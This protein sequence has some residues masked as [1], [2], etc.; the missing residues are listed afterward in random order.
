MFLSAQALNERYSTSLQ[1]LREIAE[2][3]YFQGRLD[4]AFHL[5]RTA[6]QLLAT[7]EV[8]S[9]DK[10]KFLL[11]YGRFLVQYYFL[12]NSE[13]TLMLSIV[14]QAQQEAETLQDAFGTAT[15]LFLR[16]QTLYYQHLQTGENN[17]SDARD[18]FLQASAL[19]TTIGDS[20]E[21]AE[22]LFYTGLTH[23]RQQE[24]TQAKDYYLRALEIAEQ[25][26]NKWAESEATRH[27]TD[28]SNGDQ[29][30][31]Y[32][33][34]SLERRSEMHYKP[35]LPPAQ[36]LLSEI[37]TNRGEL[38]QALAYCEQAE[39]LATEMNLQNYLVFALLTKGTIAHK[40]GELTKARKYFEEASK[41]AQQLNIAFAI[42]AANE[43]LQSLDRTE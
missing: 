9:I 5:W 16:G 29:R 27:L 32:A 24:A 8:G 3:Y 39:K 11:R 36:L 34:R 40:Q 7:P 31:H 30:L 21:L 2:A 12:M 25:Q 18:Y 20:Y 33:L 19:R 38:E 17:Y 15:A 13:E 35:G 43:Q 10:M 28:H 23:D 6:E 14:Q 4:D 42:A 22:S 41:R 26:G 37:Y 1:A